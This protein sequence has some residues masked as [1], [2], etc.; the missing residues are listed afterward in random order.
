M[1]VDIIK[2]F[3]VYN[4]HPAAFLDIRK[5]RQDFVANHV[6]FT[7]EKAFLSVCSQFIIM[8]VPTGYQQ[9]DRG[10]FLIFYIKNI[11]GVTATSIGYV[12]GPFSVHLHFWYVLGTRVPRLSR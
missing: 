6:F 1:H 4:P 9:Q 8:A 5:L 12:L 10:K 7:A 11:S 2:T 3:Y